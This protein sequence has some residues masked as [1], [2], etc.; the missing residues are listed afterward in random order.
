MFWPF[1]ILTENCGL[2]TKI[3]FENKFHKNEFQNLF[4]PLKTLVN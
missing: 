1:G 2:S 4:I 3:E